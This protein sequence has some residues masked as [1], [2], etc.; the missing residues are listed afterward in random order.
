M[1]CAL[2]VLDANETATGNVVVLV[3][4]SAS[5]DVAFTAAVD[6]DQ[7]DS[8][9]EDNTATDFTELDAPPRRVT[10]LKA[11]GSGTHIDLSWTR[12]GDN[13][14]P[15]TAYDLERKEGSGDYALAFPAPGISAAAYR[16]SQVSEGTTYTYRLRA[17]NADGSA[18]WSNEVEATTRTT[19]PRRRSGGGGGGGGGS[20]N[21]SGNDY[22]EFA[23]GNRTS[24]SAAENTP[25]GTP[26]GRPVSATDEDRDTLAYVMKGDDASFFALDGESGQL[27]TSAPLDHEARD[28]YRLWMDVSDGKDG[29]DT[30]T[31]DITVTDVDEGPVLT[32]DAAIDYPEGG[33]GDAAAYTAVDPEGAEVGWTLTGDDAGAFSINT[34]DLSFRTPPDFETPG[35][36]DEDNVYT[37]TVEASDGTNASSL[38]V[39]VTVTNVDEGPV[40]RGDAAV[41]YPEGGAGDAATYTAVDPEG[42]DIAWTLTGDDAGSFFVDGGTVSFRAPPDF[43]EPADANGDNVYT[44]TVE[45]SGGAGAASLDV[46]IT[47]TDVDLGSPYDADANEV[48]DKD[49]AISAAVDYFAGL[50]DKDEVVSVIVLYFLG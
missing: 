47:V 40:L 1:T 26:I 43:E 35:D 41:D 8:R 36:A 28:S 34:G 14:D 21:G 23:D 50:I 39:A 4:P 42:D 9:P 12:P 33:T 11:V 45:A 49:E 48:I 19:P 46:T 29:I 3:K 15:V 6:S 27:L 32:G 30:I 24:R 2:G 22:P 31:I 5:A 16:D 44:I 18:E 13:G 20:G 10:D 37:V 17:V 38:E 25:K 7:L